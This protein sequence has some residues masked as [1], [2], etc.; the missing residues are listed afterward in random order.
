M[1]P[2]SAIHGFTSRISWHSEVEQ[3]KMTHQEGFWCLA[4]GYAKQDVAV[5]SGFEKS[6]NEE[7]V[8]LAYLQVGKGHLL[9][10]KLQPRENYGWPGHFP[11]S[12]FT[13]TCPEYHSSV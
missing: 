8:N 9:F 13:E 6:I 10:I 5:S 12:S 11:L 7:V 4:Q 3:L 1:F 2:F